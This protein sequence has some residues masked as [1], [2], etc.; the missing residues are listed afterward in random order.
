MKATICSSLVLAAVAQAAST[1]AA[2]PEARGVFDDLSNAINQAFNTQQDGTTTT[3][4]AATTSPETNIFEELDLFFSNIG[5]SFTNWMDS[6]GEQSAPAQQQWQTSYQQLQN[7]VSD[8]TNSN[9]RD[10][11]CGLTD[12]LNQFFDSDLP[13]LGFTDAPADTVDTFDLH[14]HMGRWYQ[15]YAGEF[16]ASGGESQMACITHKYTKNDD[17]TFSVNDAWSRVDNPGVKYGGMY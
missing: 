11:L 8:P 2:E 3:S 5:D 13:Q 16:I 14:K 1:P 4:N 10:V 6:L 17:G 7:A 9:T 12:S 15:V